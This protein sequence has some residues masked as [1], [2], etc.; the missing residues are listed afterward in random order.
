MIKQKLTKKKIIK[1]VVFIIKNKNLQEKIA[2]CGNNTK[3]D[4]LL[5]LSGKIN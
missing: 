1:Q 5:N 2:T 3:Y 4:A